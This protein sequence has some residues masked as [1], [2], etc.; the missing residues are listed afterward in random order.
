MKIQLSET[1]D[2]EPI[3]D[4]HAEPTFDLIDRNRA[5]LKT[6]LTWV[7]YMQSVDNFRSFINGAKQRMADKQEVSFM[8][9]HEGKVAGRIGL[10]YLDHQNKI[11]NIG[12]WLG[13][14]FEGKGLVTQACQ[15]IIRL[16][17]T[18]LGLNRIEVKC[19]T[20]NVKSQAIPE[21]LGFT[22]EGVLRQA[23]FVNGQF[24]DL[25]IYSLLKTEWEKHL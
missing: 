21:R 24:H 14:E 3:D 1:I 8:I 19:A 5:H 25:N 23:E 4:R 16:G 11:A 17:F 22:K 13:K 20:G 10:Y 18:E 12:Y 2:L 15:E 6:F 7:D 9:F